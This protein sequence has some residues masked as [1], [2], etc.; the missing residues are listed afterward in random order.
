MSHFTDGESEAQGEEKKKLDAKPKS[1]NWEVHAMSLY[2]IF[3][4]APNIQPS[5]IIVSI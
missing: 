1:R 4:L 2:D 3:K 5:I